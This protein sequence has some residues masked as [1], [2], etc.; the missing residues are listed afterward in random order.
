MSKENYTHIIMILDRSGSMS[1]I[2]KD[3]EGGL[4][5]FITKQQKVEGEATLTFAQ[6]DDKYELV[7]DNVIIADVEKLDLEPRGGTA[8]LDAIGKTLNTER[9]RIKKMN[10][11]DQPSKIACVIITDGEENSSR[12]YTQEQIKEKTEKQ[13]KDNNWDFIFMGADQDAWSNAKGYGIGNSVNFSQKDMGKTI[14]G[15][16]YYS[17]N[18]RNY[19]ADLSMDNFN[20]TEDQLDD[21]IE[22]L[23]N[24][25]KK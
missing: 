7:H 23:K 21:K 13:T 12:E 18:A 19:S 3:M 2:K 5:E 20:L 10:E 1:T 6:F 17:S 9:D 22:D 16:T 25:P 14:K 11:N 8:L 24:T 4:N 15:A